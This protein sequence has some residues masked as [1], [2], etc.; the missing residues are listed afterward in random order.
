MAKHKRQE[1]KDKTYQGCAELFRQKN[2][3]GYQ[4]NEPSTHKTVSALEFMWEPVK[5]EG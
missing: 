3:G 2:D 1:K 5:N 4:L